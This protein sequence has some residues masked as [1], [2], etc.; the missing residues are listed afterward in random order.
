MQEALDTET[1]GMVNNYI[2]SATQPGLSQGEIDAALDKARGC[3]DSYQEL[4]RLFNRVY[5]RLTPQIVAQAR[6]SQE[7]TIR[8]QRN[9]NGLGGWNQNFSW[10]DLPSILATDVGA[11]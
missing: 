1:Y 11:K 2:T 4:L 5:Q 7:D 6:K 9:F 3:L 8:R 10:N